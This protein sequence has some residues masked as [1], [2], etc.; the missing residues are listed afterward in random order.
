MGK[1]DAGMCPSGDGAV[2]DPGRE[3]TERVNGTEEFKGNCLQGVER[4]KGSHKGWVSA[5]G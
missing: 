3:L 1:Q 5:H 2:Q 4:G